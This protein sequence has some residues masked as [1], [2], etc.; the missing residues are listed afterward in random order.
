MPSDPTTMITS[1]DHNDHLNSP[2]TFS[3]C[4]EGEIPSRSSCSEAR[5]VGQFYFGDLARKWVNIQP[6]LTKWHSINERLYAVA[7][8]REQGVEI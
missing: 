7:M 4:G 1:S 3:R 6:A 8:L 5:R 2:A